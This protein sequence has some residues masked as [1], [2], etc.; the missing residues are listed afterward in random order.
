MQQQT[1]C[2]VHGHECH[3]GLFSRNLFVGQRIPLAGV[4]H[5]NGTI[6][7]GHDPEDVG[8]GRR[9]AGRTRWTT[10][11]SWT[12]ASSPRAAAVNPA[13]TIMANA[14]R[15]GDRILE[16]LGARRSQAASSR[17][18]AVRVM[19]DAGDARLS[20]GA[21]PAAAR[22]RP[23]CWLGAASLGAQSPQP[24]PAAGAVPQAGG[25]RDERRRGRG[26]GGRRW[27]GSRSRDMDRSVAFYTSVLDFQK[28]SDDE[29]AG[30]AYEKLEGVF[31]R[32][33]AGRAPEAGRR[34]APAHRVPGAAR[35]SRAG[36][37]AQQRPLVPARRHRR[38]RHGQRLCPPAAEQGAARLDRAAAP[39]QD[40]PQRR[41]HPGVLF[42]GP[43]RPP[44]RAPAVPGGQG[45]PQVA[46]AERPAVPGHRPHRHRGERYRR[47][48]WRSIATCSASGWP[49]RA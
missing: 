41:R 42:S 38:Q 5:Q 26:P 22:R 7:F 3:Q 18:R 47:R 20:C 32:P 34:A 1:R 17:R 15:V 29:V 33:H 4:A 14:L 35:A 21:V 37:L 16:R 2:A 48:A 12:A 27:W 9:T 11:T 10:S 39:A 49:E 46:R 45:R 8:A 19:S 23:R 44:A 28:V 36:R 31:G 13:L 24:W 25:Q 6:R 43:R 40:H 30:S